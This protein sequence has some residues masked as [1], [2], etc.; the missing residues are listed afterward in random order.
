[1]GDG[2]E[3]QP[4]SLSEHEQDIRQVMEQ[5]SGAVNSVRSV[6]D[7]QAFGIIGQVWATGLNAWIQQH[8]SCVDS[9]VK[10]GESVADSVAKMNQNYQQNEDDVAQSFTSISGD[11]GA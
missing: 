10:A 4:A 2:Y 1:M 8:T 3:V 7:P 11:M 9:A 5:V 6:F